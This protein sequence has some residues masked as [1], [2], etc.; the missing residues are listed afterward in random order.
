MQF[1]ISNE[2]VRSHLIVFAKKTGDDPRGIDEEHVAVDRALMNIGGSIVQDRYFRMYTSGTIVVRKQED[3]YIISLPELEEEG[4]GSAYCELCR[5]GLDWWSKQ[6]MASSGIHKVQVGHLSVGEKPQ[7]FAGVCVQCQDGYC[8]K[9]APDNKCPKCGESLYVET[10]SN[11][12]SKTSY[13][14]TSKDKS[15]KR[16]ILD[17]IFFWRK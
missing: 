6:I 5:K 12:D 8:K 1:Q 14:P 2:E 17:K 9:H 11:S 16:T 15:Q 13:S 4:S 7:Y 3:G 10:S